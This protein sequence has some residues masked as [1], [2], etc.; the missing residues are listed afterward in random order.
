MNT[1][2]LDTTVNELE[3][4]LR[5]NSPN[6]LHVLAEAAG[7]SSRAK[8]AEPPFVAEPPLQTETPFLAEPPLLHTEHVS[9]D[10][11]DGMLPRRYEP[12]QLGDPEDAVIEIGRAHV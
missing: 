5:G 2:L 9:D 8:I 4:F 6:N 7:R 1:F 12:V 3:E 10:Q 11:I